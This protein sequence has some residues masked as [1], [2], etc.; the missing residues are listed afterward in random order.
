MP[1]PS[2]RHIDQITFNSPEEEKSIFEHTLAHYRAGRVTKEAIE[3]GKQYGSHIASAY[4][5]QVSVRYISEQIGHGLFAE[6]EIKKGSFV[7]EYTGIV[8]RNPPYPV[9]FSD[10]AYEYPVP[11]LIGRS[12]V[13]DAIAGNLTRF[14]NH[15][16]TTPNLKPL[17]AYCGNYYHLIFLSLRTI[18]PNEQ[19]LYDYGHHY[20]NLRAHPHDLI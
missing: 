6:E 10:Y 17:H 18:A 13:T 19:L 11:D 15:S 14:I 4:I 8:R 20:W 9:I 2:Y 3:L 16:R 7:G 12:F 1:I 5:P